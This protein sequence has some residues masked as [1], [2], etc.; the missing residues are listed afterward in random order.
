MGG[1]LL[2]SWVG[3]PNEKLGNDF[4]TRMTCMGLGL[5]LFMGGMLLKSWVGEPPSFWKWYEDDHDHTPPFLK[6]REAE[7][8]ASFPPCF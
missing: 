3:G 6:R 2:K 5:E 7:I 8:M 1:M 4:Q